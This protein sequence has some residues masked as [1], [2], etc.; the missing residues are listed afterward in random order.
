REVSAC[1]RQS[2]ELE[3]RIRQHL[4]LRPAAW[5]ALDS[6]CGPWWAPRTGEPEESRQYGCLRLELE[7][8]L[9]YRTLLAVSRVP[10]GLPAWSGQWARVAEEAPFPVDWCLRSRPL[11]GSPVVPELATAILFCVWAENL[12]ELDERVAHLRR[13]CAGQ[14]LHLDRPRNRQPALHAAMWPP[15]PFS[16][17]LNPYLQLVALQDLGPAL[18]ERAA[19]ERIVS[20]PTPSPGYLLRIRRGPRQGVQV[21]LKREIVIGRDGADLD[22]EDPSASTRHVA[23]IPLD[24]GVV[25]RSVGASGRTRV[26]GRWVEDETD[27]E[28]GQSFVAGNSELILLQ[29]GLPPTPAEG[30]ASGRRTSQELAIGIDGQAE[31]WNVRI[32]AGGEA[33]CGEV[34]RSMVEYLGLGPQAGY[35]AYRQR[36]GL[37]LP[38]AGLWRRSG[39]LRGDILEIG[40]VAEGSPA[41]PESDLALSPTTPIDPAQVR[42][43]IS[44]PPRT[45][46]APSPLR[47]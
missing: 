28:P 7:G 6:I 27:L 26:Q 24:G 5:D 31:V 46:S 14:A 20:A 15:A 34:T 42:T 44:R 43:T 40:A 19:P 37:Y 22:L 41:L 17:A 3:A 1:S 9:A 47:V 8:G 25:L 18:A 35:C 21:P 2:E 36:G 12:I 16:P 10:R 38:A 13:A 4:S 32:E 29:Y 45:I 23:V 11:P 33:T 39:V 30:A